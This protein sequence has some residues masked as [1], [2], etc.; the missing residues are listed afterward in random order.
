M[1]CFSDVLGAA[2]HAAALVEAAVSAACSKDVWSLGWETGAL[3]FKRDCS[4][5][6]F[7][8]KSQNPIDMYIRP[9]FVDEWSRISSARK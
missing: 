3:R 4:A 1:E 9:I 6:I 2:C 5:C 7:E 8:F